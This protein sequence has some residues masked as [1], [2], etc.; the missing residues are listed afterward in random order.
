M[1]LRSDPELG[2]CTENHPMSCVAR[3]GIETRVVGVVT[4]W[5]G[6]SPAGFVRGWLASPPHRAIMLDARYRE[7][8]VWTGTGTARVVFVR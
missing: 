4:A 1:P 6:S 3:L 7:A 5:G 2:R 8:G